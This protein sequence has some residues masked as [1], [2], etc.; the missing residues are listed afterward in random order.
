MDDKARYRKG[1]AFIFILSH[2][3]IAGDE[4]DNRTSL[5]E[6]VFVFVRV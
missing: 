3:V 6:K 4:E 1:G 5:I 2:D